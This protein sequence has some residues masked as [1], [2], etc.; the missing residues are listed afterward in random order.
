M[1][2]KQKLGIVLYVLGIAILLANGID[3][4]SGFFG[5]RLGIRVVSSG[6]GVAFF[7]LGMSLTGMYSPKKEKKVKKKK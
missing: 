1:K 7:V 4:L 6:V 5:P 3:Y 2:N